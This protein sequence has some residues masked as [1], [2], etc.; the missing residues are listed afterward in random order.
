MSPVVLEKVPAEPLLGQIDRGLESDDPA[1]ARKALAQVRQEIL[2]QVRPLSAGQAAALLGVSPATVRNLKKAGLLRPAHG[3]RRTHT[4]VSYESV[5]R[6]RPIVLDL[7]RIRKNRRLVQRL[8]AR[9]D[10]DGFELKAETHGIL[11]A[12]LHRVQTAVDRGETIRLR[13]S[14]KE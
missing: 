3:D 12:G 7:R 8:V 6:L 13:S 2:R 11:K 14:K 9:L 5:S 1:A 4:L 10:A